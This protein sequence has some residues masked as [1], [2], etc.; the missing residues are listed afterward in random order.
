MKQAKQ[1]DLSSLQREKTKPKKKQVSNKLDTSLQW[2]QSWS[3]PAN[4]APPGGEGQA[5]T[6]VTVRAGGYQDFESIQ[7]T[8]V[9]CTMIDAF[10]EI[11]ADTP[12]TFLAYIQRDINCLVED[13]LRVRQNS[14]QK[15]ER[16]LVNQIDSLS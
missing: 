11:P 16:I 1:V 9:P 8:E 12:E 3:T 14:L 5:G 2:M 4:P 10:E 6:V 13:N 7:Q 15:L